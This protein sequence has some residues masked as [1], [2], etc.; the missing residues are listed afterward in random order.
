MVL[1]FSLENEQTL[2]DG[3]PVSFTVSGKRSIDIGRDRHLDWTLPD[4][5]RL[6]SG[7]HCEV[8]Y[9]DGGYWLHDVSTNGTFLN[10]SQQRMGEPHRLRNG[11]QI[12]IGHYIINVAL[13]SD[14]AMPAGNKPAQT[15]GLVSQQHADYR[16]LWTSDRDVPPPIDPQQLKIAREVARPVNPGFLDWAAAVPEPDVDRGQRSPFRKTVD[17]SDQGDM[18]WA[19]GTAEVPKQPEPRPAVPAPRRPLWADDDV[20]GRD[21]GFVLGSPP[22]SSVEPQRPRAETPPP[23]AVQHRAAPSSAEN[24]PSGAGNNQ[25]IEFARHLAKAAG[26]PENFFAD[27]DAA[28]LAEQFG[29]ILRITVDNLMDLLQARHQAKQMTRSTN[30]TMIQAVENNPLKFSPTAEDA[31]RILFGPATRS[32]LDARGAFVQGFGDLKSHQLKTYMAMQH[33][34]ARLVASIDPTVLAREIEAERGSG[35][36][37]GSGK[38]KLWDAF[39]LRWK[40]QLGRDSNAPID[41][42]MLHFASFYDHDG[43]VD[44]K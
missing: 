30:Q 40:A 14:E 28:E 2:P 13:D 21:D 43:K 38:G 3:G 25:A 34:V 12:T 27:K 22:S 4:P 44:K 26:L 33:A 1:R 18:S 9:R 11:D 6:I 24:V 29:T 35:F 37:L 15:A 8:H 23:P 36:R 19:A 5:T 32:Y 16:E 41:A 10:G 7:K 31:M 42:F 20:S 17:K 39:M